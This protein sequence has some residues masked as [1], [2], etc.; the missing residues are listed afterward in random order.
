M[1][2]YLIELSI[3]ILGVTIALIF[4]NAN[5]S[6][7]NAEKLEISIN[8]IKQELVSHELAFTT[9][10]DSQY[11]IINAAKTDSSF[12]ISVSKLV[13]SDA[14]YQLILNNNSLEF[15]D[16]EKSSAILDYY[17]RT[18]ALESIE[19]NMFDAYS[20]YLLSGESNV[21]LHWMVSLTAIEQELLIAN[22]KLQEK[23]AE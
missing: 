7:Q 5:E 1:K 14:A 3:I 10:L 8:T 9:S 23:L 6:W 21:L 18:R 2:K 16:H 20:H 17:C 19:K 15:M 4:E 11:K 13:L 12:S 22:K